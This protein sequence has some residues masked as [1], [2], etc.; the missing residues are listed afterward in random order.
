MRLHRAPFNQAL[1]ASWDGLPTSL[2][3]VS[4]IPGHAAPFFPAAIPY[5]ELPN[6]CLVTVGACRWRHRVG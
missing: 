6:S 3:V 5:S 2:Q 1:T 4:I